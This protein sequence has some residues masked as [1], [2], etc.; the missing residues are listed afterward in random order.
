MRDK[1]EKIF[2]EFISETY[3][4]KEIIKKYFLNH[5]RKKVCIDNLCDQIKIIEKQNYYI[6]FNQEKY[7]Y[8]IRETAKMF[9]HI[10]I[11]YAEQKSYSKSK[12]NLMISENNR[13]NS[14]EQEFNE[15]QKESL[16][17]KIISYPKN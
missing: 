15:L 3:K 11:E 9:C 8:T 4:E 6:K 7:R 14:L 10:A 12:I 16:S 2:N 17:N 13:M 1:I 5:E